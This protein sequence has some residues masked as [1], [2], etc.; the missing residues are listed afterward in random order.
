MGDGTHTGAFR[1]SML[2]GFLWSD[3]VARLCGTTMVACFIGRCTAAFAGISASTCRHRRALWARSSLKSGIGVVQNC[4]ILHPRLK[5]LGPELLGP[6]TRS[7]AS[8]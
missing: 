4:C 1:A 8:E 7:G 3:S 2:Q 6:C 5:A